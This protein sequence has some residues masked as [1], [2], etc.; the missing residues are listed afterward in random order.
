M[1]L[2]LDLLHEEHAQLQQSKRDPLKLGL[3]ALVG[4]AALFIAYY[5][6][7]LVSVGSL[8]HQLA[9]RQADWR[10]QEPLATAAEKQEKEI[11]EQLAAAAAVARRVEGRFYWAP[12]LEVLFKSVTS[13]VQLVS[14]N[15]NNEVRDEKVKLTLE[16]LAAG[17]EPRAAAEQFRTALAERLG[18]SFP[19]ASAT[20]RSLE[21][22]VTPVN[23]NGK[24]TPNARFTIEVSMKKPVVETATNLQPV[25]ERRSRHS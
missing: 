9:V 14:F 4:V 11:N 2:T 8:K 22:S 6:I 20:F 15:G 23:L 17:S 16:G 1:P 21:E 10:K 19:D 25:T 13:N 3:Y 24:P 18:K 12:V 5:G 7:R